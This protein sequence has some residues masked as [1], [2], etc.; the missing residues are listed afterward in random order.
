MHLE[1]QFTSGMSWSNYAGCLPWKSKMKKWHIDHIV[2]KS[3]FWFDDRRAAYALANLRPLWEK[4]N[5]RKGAVQTIL[6]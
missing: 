5:L 2:P 4:D 1:R 6:L 3:K